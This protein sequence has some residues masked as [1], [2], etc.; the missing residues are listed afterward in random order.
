MK[1]L[2]HK[3]LLLAIVVISMYAVP[4]YAQTATTAT[5]QEV[6][7]VA[8][9]YVTK[10]GEKYHAGNCGYLHSS[11][12]QTTLEVAKL[13]GYTA[14]SRCKGAASYA[15]KTKT[16]NA[17]IKSVVA[18]QCSGTTQAGNRCKRRTKDP[19]GRCY[20]H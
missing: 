3:I 20:Q 18:V 16:N 6:K 4:S 7:K 10:T 1:R 2:H 15:P 14:C 8:I 9:V 5:Q 12:I 17:P 19:S 13:S 11:K